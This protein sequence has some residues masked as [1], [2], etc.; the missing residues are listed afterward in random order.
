MY[1]TTIYKHVKRETM[2]TN[3]QAIKSVVIILNETLLHFFGTK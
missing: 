3:V 2:L 1:H